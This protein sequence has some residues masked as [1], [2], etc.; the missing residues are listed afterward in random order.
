MII[1]TLIVAWIVFTIL[2]K[3]IKTTVRLAFTIAAIIVLLQIGFDISPFDVLNYIVQFFQNASGVIE[4]S[5]S[6]KDLIDTNN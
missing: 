3:V 6:I 1:L 4:N 5:G 2:V